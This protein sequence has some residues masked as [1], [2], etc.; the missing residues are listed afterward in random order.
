MFVKPACNG[1]LIDTAQFPPENITHNFCSI[2]IYNKFVLIFR[3]F[4][5]TVWCKRS[6]ELTV[7]SLYL[8][9]AADLNGNISAVVIIHQVFDHD[10]KI[11]RTAS[12]DSIDSV[13]N[14]DQSDPIIRKK[15]ID[16]LSGVDIFT[17]EAGQ[18]FYNDTVHNSGADVIHHTLKVRT[19]IICPCISIVFSYRNK[20]YISLVFKVVQNKLLLIG[21]AVAFDL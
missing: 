13:V 21:N 11:V 4:F 7:L 1:I 15:T 20:I 9:L 3:R 14:C 2:N 5:V 10:V 16:I 6:D 12:R 19:V 8:Q 17:P 18:I